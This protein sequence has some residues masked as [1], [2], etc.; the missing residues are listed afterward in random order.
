MTDLCLL[1]ATENA[2]SRESL[3]GSLR[4]AAD[5]LDVVGEIERAVADAGRGIDCVLTDLRVGDATAL[6][7]L[8]E[9]DMLETTPP[10]VVAADVQSLEADG[11]SDGGGNGGGDGDGD[12]DADGGGNCDADG[13]TGPIKPDPAEADFTPDGR[14]AP[15]AV[16][17][18]G[19]SAYV[20]LDGSPGADATLIAEIERVVSGNATGH[21]ENATGHD[22]TVDETLLARLDHLHEATRELMRADEFDAVARTATTAASD[23]LGFELNG[24][25][26]Y[27]PAA[28]VLRPTTMSA[29][30]ETVIGERP[31]YE[32]GEAVHWEVFDSGMSRYYED[33]RTIPDEIERSGTG[34]V[35]YLPLGQYGVLSVGRESPGGIPLRDRRLAEILAANTTAAFERADRERALRQREAELADR[36]D[37]LET[38]ADAAAHDLRNPLNIVVSNARLL[39]EGNVPGDHDALGAILH[40]AER[41]E[42]IIDRYLT[43]ARNGQVVDTPER[44]SL[45][46]VASDAWQTVETESA[47][48]VTDDVAEETVA[49][50]PERLRTLFE[51]LFRNAVEHGG[52]S[53]TVHVET[54]PDGFLVRDDGPG[55]PSDTPEDLFA[56]GTSDNSEGTGLGLA[57]VRRIAEAHDWTVSAETASAEN[58]ESRGS[59]EGGAVFRFVTSEGV[60][61]PE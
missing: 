54:T 59:S 35:I 51:N 38:F 55:F 1:Y 41:M 5:S 28:D 22:E 60:T 37:R 32:R 53:V 15:E 23:V 10:V 14:S 34:S 43:L 24:V 49:A 25:R 13:G 3:V 19:A 29:E 46:R 30:T 33:V 47:T 18:A 45:E 11:G 20:R 8:A 9:L 2:S 57:F 31:V 40:S 58:A 17:D 42:E 16:Y 48:L 26:L 52:S 4:D 27:D 7:L 50:D 61:L 56:A 36:N 39:R 44:V 12:S 21:D 6:D